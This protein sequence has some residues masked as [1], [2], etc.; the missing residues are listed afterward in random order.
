ML[1][2]KLKIGGREAW[3]DPVLKKRRRNNP[4]IVG[5]M[6]Q[7]GHEL[8]EVKPLINAHTVIIIIYHLLKMICV[9]LTV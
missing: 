7:R 4:Y 5:Q 3:I 9:C 6:R 2:G 8:S 1:Q